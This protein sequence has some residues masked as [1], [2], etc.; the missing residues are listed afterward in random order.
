MW[1]LAFHWLVTKPVMLLI[2]GLNVR[3]LERLPRWGPAIV[4]ANHNSHADI[5]ALTSLFPSRVLRKVRPVAAADYFLRSRPMSWFA[6][7]CMGILPLDRHARDHGRDPLIECVEALD[8]GE[9]LILF[10]EGS[11]GEPEKLQRFK[12]GI[13]HLAQRR[14]DVPIVPVHLHGLG[15]VLPKG[16]F[17]PVPLFCDAFVGSPM[18]DRPA[19][20]HHFVEALEVAMAQL[21]EGT[22]FSVWQ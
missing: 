19:E 18:A 17:V 20:S 1:R 5:V 2:V 9:I 11:R 8:R 15:K 21:T 22:Q 13:Y 3:H 16:S 6:R 14:P 7:N 10:P 12:K 4:V